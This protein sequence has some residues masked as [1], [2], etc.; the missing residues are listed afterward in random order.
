MY[1]V[2]IDFDDASREWNKNKTR[3]EYGCYTYKCI[4]KCQGK[5]K[6]GNQCKLKTP[7]DKCHIHEK[8][9]GLK[10]KN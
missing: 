8:N 3:H 9:I 1:E 10:K 7:F 2:N 5:T 6:G 4:N